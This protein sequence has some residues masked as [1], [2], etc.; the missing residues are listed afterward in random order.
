M[1]DK[2]F[3]MIG[4][5]GAAQCSVLAVTFDELVCDLRWNVGAALN[6]EK[7]KAIKRGD[8]VEITK[9][10]NLFNSYDERWNEVRRLAALGLPAHSGQY[11]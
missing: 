2:W 3:L 7:I 10:W 5:E 6:I 11:R 1:D 8:F 4:Y 9:T